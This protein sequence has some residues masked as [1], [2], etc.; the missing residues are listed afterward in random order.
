MLVFCAK[1]QGKNTFC[2][3]LVNRMLGRHARAAYMDCDLGQPEFTTP[4]L[5]SIHRLDAPVLGP[6]H[7]NIRRPELA[8][9]IG[10]TTSKSEPLLYFAAVRTLAKHAAAEDQGAAS[11]AGD[12]PPGRSS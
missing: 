11:L 12:R 9:F 6:P 5:V 8:Y 10:T 7:S 4:G 1:G 2:R 3:L